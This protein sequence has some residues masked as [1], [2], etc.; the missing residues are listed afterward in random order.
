MVTLCSEANSTRGKQKD[1]HTYIVMIAVVLITDGRQ[2]GQIDK[3]TDRETDIYR[4]TDE[5]RDG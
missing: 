5:W 2:D 1:S 4:L 3:Q